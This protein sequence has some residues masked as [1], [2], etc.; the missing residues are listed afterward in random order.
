MVMWEALE[1]GL[2]GHISSG[3]DC[4]KSVLPEVE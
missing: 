3:Q 2:D 1:L 4:K